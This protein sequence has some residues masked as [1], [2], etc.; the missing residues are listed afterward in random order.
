MVLVMARETPMAVT[1]TREQRRLEN[2][3]GRSRS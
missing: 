2:Q 3:E 1:T